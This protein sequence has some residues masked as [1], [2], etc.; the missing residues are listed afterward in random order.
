MTN[1]THTNKGFTLLEFAIASLATMIL[2]A[3]AFTLMSNMFRA[4]A[5][6]MQVMQTQQNL[7]VAMNTIARDVTM[8][9]TG[10][11]TGGIAVPNGANSVTLTRPGVG[12]T[13][14]TPNSAIAM[15]APGDGDDPVELGLGRQ[16]VDD[17]VEA[18]MGRAAVAPL[19]T[20]GCPASKLQR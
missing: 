2:L 4:S 20:S 15:V 12:G 11:P 7:R 14:S 17:Q 3:A 18:R 1:M 19:T 8:A 13:L 16:Q 10:L 6:M 9:G 5:N